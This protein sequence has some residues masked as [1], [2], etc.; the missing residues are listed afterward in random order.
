MQPTT[1]GSGGAFLLEQPAPGDIFTPEDY[2]DEHL[3]IARTT[4][5]FWNTEVAPNLDAVLER[6]PGVAV[7]LLRK[8]AELGLAAVLTPERYGGMELDIVS[9]MI[10]AER[11][12]RDASFSAWHAAHAGPG[13][14]A[15]LLFG[16]EELRQRYLT[17]LAAGEMV[18][19]FCLTEPQAGSDASAISTRATL[20]PDGTHYLLTGHKL[21]V[22]NAGGADLF[23]VLA[24]VGGEK[25]T[26]FL[27][28]RS[29][30]GLHVGPEEDKM[31]LDGSSDCAL[32]LDDVPV[33]AGNVLG[34]IGQGARIAHAVLNHARL[35]R[36]ASAAGASKHV[37]AA[38]LRHAASRVA[39]GKAIAEFG[40]IRHK[41][42]EM[43][44]RTFAV[45]SMT[46][47]VAGL[48][49]VRLKDLSW[50]SP[51][52]AQVTVEALEEFAVECCLVKIF[53]TEALGEVVDEAVQIYGGQGYRRGNPAARAFRDARAGRILEGTNEVLR[54]LAALLLLKRATRGR[55]PLMPALAG[56]P[57]QILAAPPAPPVAA[58]TLAQETAL[59][60][61][62]KRAALLVLGAAFSKYAAS[63]TERQEILAGFAGIA[64]QALALESACLRARKL[65][66]Q[67]AGETAAAMCAVLARQ[68][69]DRVETAARELLAACAEGDALR[70]SLAALRRLAACQPADLIA[71]RGRIAGR[72]SE[73][74]NYLV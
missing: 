9:S 29:F 2:S 50:D 60:A 71:L 26:A 42:A 63:L 3:S 22:T 56:L 57:D 52:A 58:G 37:L 15:L 21:W 14:M 33:P 43:A 8:S 65:A 30:P 10:V 54:L 74:G 6:R 35:M 11:L 27:V 73:A 70:V 66:A 59:A 20:A 18:A 13:C 48:I 16:S 4:D 53:A 31:G 64:A 25:L 72:L 5:E 40:L 61:A 17:K 28:E 19:S 7:S 36:G 68:V 62:A 41:L 47:R 34:E 69:M 67:G 12:A 39:F 45:E 55:L 32:L 46:C 44:I 1:G 38:C 49:D 24:K 23:T 51:G